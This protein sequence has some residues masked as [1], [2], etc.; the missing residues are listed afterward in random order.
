[1]HQIRRTLSTLLAI[2]LRER[3]K[4]NEKNSE[5]E[6]KYIY[7]K[8]KQTRT[9]TQKHKQTK[10][11]SVNSQL[12]RNQPIR[13]QPSRLRAEYCSK[14]YVVHSCPTSAARSVCGLVPGGIRIHLHSL[15]LSPFAP[16]AQTGHHH[17]FSIQRCGVVGLTV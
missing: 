7:I 10:Q 17:Y 8:N 5:K 12:L 13:Y 4:K 6:T 15:S 3:H 1:M 16:L 2:Q 14:L 11:M 9:N